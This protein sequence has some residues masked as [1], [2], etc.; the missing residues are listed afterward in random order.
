[1]S[2]FNRRD[3]LK[4]TGLT[5]G[6]IGMFGQ[7][8]VAAEEIKAK[9]KTASPTRRDTSKNKVL[10]VGM[11]GMMPEQIERYKDDIPELAEFIK[12]GFFYLF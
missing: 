11:D 2:A 4:T 10:L 7:K 1:M 3:F 9:N 8:A 6:T 5:A 12:N